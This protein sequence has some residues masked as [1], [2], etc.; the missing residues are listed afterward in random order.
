[1]TRNAT[2]RRAIGHAVP[3][4]STPRLILLP[5]MRDPTGDPR[6]ALALGRAVIVFV[7]I[8]AA[9]AAKRAMEAGR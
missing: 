5:D 4:T 9:L 8:R 2:T 6:P 3:P 1:M 7:T